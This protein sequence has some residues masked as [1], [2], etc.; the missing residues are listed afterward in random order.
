MNNLK[1]NLMHVAH[2]SSAVTVGICIAYID[3]S[4]QTLGVIAGF[5]GLLY[6]AYAAVEEREFRNS[7]NPVAEQAAKATGFDLSTLDNLDRD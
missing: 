4:V 5:T 1:T 2:L 7:R 6:V 3:L